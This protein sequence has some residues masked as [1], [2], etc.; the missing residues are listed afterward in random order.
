M[1]T[2]FDGFHDASKSITRLAPIKSMPKQPA[3]V[4][5]RKSLRIYIGKFR[6]QLVIHTT[7]FK[8]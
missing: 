6:T 5:R 8:H 7:F 3:R 4:E 1:L 2:S